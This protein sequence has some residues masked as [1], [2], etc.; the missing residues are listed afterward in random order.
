[1]LTPDVYKIQHCKVHKV[2]IHYLKKENEAVL[3]TQCWDCAREVSNK[4]FK[5]QLRQAKKEDYEICKIIV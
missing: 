5:E 2:T 3:E 4:K 1:M